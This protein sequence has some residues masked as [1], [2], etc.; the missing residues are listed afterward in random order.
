MAK[1]TFALIGSESLLGREIR[2][3]VATSAPD[4]DLRLIA[5]DEESPGT[6]TR[7]GDEPAM[8]MEL[9]ARSLEDARAVFLAGSPESSRKALELLSQ[10][11]TPAIDLTA[12]ADEHLDARLRAQSPECR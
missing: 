10:D 5:A 7:V 1:E 3:V 2:D 12:T 11:S 8:V 4:L 9:D 6:L